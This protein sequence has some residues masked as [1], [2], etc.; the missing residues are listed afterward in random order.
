MRN[1][2]KTITTANQ[3]TAQLDPTRLLIKLKEGV[4]TPGAFASLQ[5][6]FLVEEE[7]ERVSLQSGDAKNEREKK[8]ERI[9]PQLNNSNNKIWVKTADGSELNEEQLSKIDEELG[10][11]AE[12][13]SP[14]YYIPGDTGFEVRF[15][16]KSDVI[17]VPDY[18]KSRG[19]QD[20]FLKSLGFEEIESK[21]RLL[22]KFRYF[23]LKDP[24]KFGFHEL[25]EKLL[26]H[27][28]VLGKV[29]FENVPMYKPIT[30]TTPN[31]DLWGDQWNML[32]IHAPDAWDHTT[33]SN[34]VVVCILDE[35]CDLSHPD[36]AFSED[37]INL[38]TM[39]PTGEPTGDHGTACAGIA[40]ATFNNSEGVAGVAGNCLIMP[41]AFS[42][43]SDVEC[44]NG[45]NYATTN[46]AS[47][48]SMSFGVY[49]DWGWDYSIIDPEIQNA[50]N[51][52]VV[53]CV[54][55][56]NE[57]DAATNRYPGKH[58][59]V[60]GCGA[61]STDDNRK[62]KTSPDGE[63]FW[64]ANY[65]EDTYDGVV[66]GVSVVAPGVLI[67]TTDRQGGDGY[68][69]GDYTMEFNGTSSAT[70][71]VAGLACLIRSVE[72]V[73]T[74]S[75]VRD[76]IELTAEKVGS[77]G[78]AANADF[79]NGTRNQEMGYGRINALH[80]V[81]KAGWEITPVQIE[82][83]FIDIPEGETQLRAIRIDV[84]SF[85]ETRFELSV[86]P[87]APFGLHNYS[88]PIILGK[89]TDYDTP[90][91]VFIWVKYTGTNAGDTASGTAEV[92][93]NTTNEVFLVT[94]SANTVA[95]PTCA[96]TL[97]LDQS[98]SMLW[99]SGVG[100]LTREEVLKYSA[101][102]F[103]GY[104]RE[105]NG[106]G[107]VTFDQDAHDLLHPL[108][109]P[110][111]PADDPFDPARSAA[112]TAFGSYAANPSGATAIGDGIERAH[113]NM[114]G[115]TG[116]EKKAI[117]VF[118]DGHETDSKYIADVEGLIDEQVFAVGL[119]TAGQLNPA[120]LDSICNNTGGYL[121][122]TDS[123]DDDDTFKIAKYFLQIQA[124]VNNE[125]IVVD[126]TGYV[127]PGQKVK[128]PFRVNDADIS[129]DTI[130]MTVM[131]EI[132]EFSIETP[133]GDI[134]D[135]SNLGTFPTVIRSDGQM[136]SYYRLT[137]PVTNAGSVEAHS[138]IWNIV[139]SV[140]KDNWKKYL[141]FLRRNDDRKSNS[142]YQAA[143]AHGVKYTALVHAYSNL[144]MNCTKSQTG[145]E[146]GAT[147]K[148]RA[149]ITEYGF[150]LDNT[151]SV[152]AELKTPD[153]LM[154][155]VVFSKTAAGIYEVAV[156]AAY[157]GVYTF[158]VKAK[159]KT[160]RNISYTRE[161]VMTA[162]VW[163]GGNNPPPS[164]DND[165]GHNPTQEAI[166]RLLT[167]LNKTGGSE[168]KA[169]LQKMG[170]DLGALAKCFCTPVKRSIRLRDV[171]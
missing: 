21:S 106:L 167:C 54:A 156:P 130:V 164:H 69:G 24:G 158:R 104:V 141:E 64:G 25:Y 102:I 136:L 81:T 118:T 159:G 170:L 18:E 114:T 62:K 39:M 45:I 125:Q 138:G 61:S 151:A 20:A 31:D 168:F 70:P 169:N 126:P 27:S 116:Y 155:D 121:M 86:P 157:A 160:S 105:N 163:R 71:H 28:T 22:R 94:I 87:S 34:A 4:D 63:D 65:G 140:N 23:K 56:G 33:G 103:V 113:N 80:A 7:P 75:Q 97:V 149:A 67:P 19:Q 127:A 133:D 83:Q 91:S 26:G 93:C 10:A 148:L 79:P 84:N 76:V 152:Q 48:I 16:P 143:L 89:T 107:L 68:D 134:I 129:I 74:G 124:G 59:L 58:P 52:N 122:L 85:H 98:G 37:G 2:L 142:M 42:D 14:V 53:M 115:V 35:G 100:S 41:L 8:Q 166:C 171:G 110:F 154:S 99:D 128:I 9:K 139:L 15:S 111:G 96:M 43:W 1:F 112:Q 40:A 13:V 144:R 135:T 66:T 108:V 82:L 90:R 17:L 109:G 36:L 78:Y 147:L 145:Y 44:A 88:G 51:N 132:L 72:P 50:F 38:S 123:L 6:T 165:P 46:G 150:A 137:M 3:K 29:R 11:S 12:S 60:I 55:T 77:I 162:A 161:Q 32:K 119:G 101:G 92:R 57:D 117:I 131:N 120:A 153:G 95:R 5:A 73:L 146:P 49:D 30:T 47:V